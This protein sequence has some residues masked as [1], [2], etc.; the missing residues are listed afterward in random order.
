MLK[1]MLLKLMYHTNK[2]IFRKILLRVQVHEEG[3]SREG[4][5]GSSGNWQ[6]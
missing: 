5:P 4:F 2:Q 3:G 6:H 1:Q